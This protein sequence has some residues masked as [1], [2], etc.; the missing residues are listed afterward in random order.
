[1]VM[2][3]KLLILIPLLF[4]IS[5]CTYDVV[6][7]THVFENNVNITGTISYNASCDSG[8]IEYIDTIYNDSNRLTINNLVNFSMVNYSI[9]QS[10]LPCDVNNDTWF[11]GT[12]VLTDRAGNAF[13]YR[14]RYSASPVSGNPYCQ[15][16]WNIGGN[17]GQLPM[18]LLTFPKGAANTQ[19]GTFTNTEYTLDTWYQNGALV[20]IE[21]TNDVEFWDIEFT[22]ER[23]HK[24]RGDY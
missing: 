8:W 23:T 22:I 21:C 12:H 19:I 15:A 10:E 5:A 18:R 3:N 1:M 17:V 11:N 24:G 13:I 16:Y 2:K 14:W 6:G 20:Q 7:D 9:R 4:L